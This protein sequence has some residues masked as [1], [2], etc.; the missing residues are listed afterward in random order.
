MG[1]STALFI[2]VIIALAIIASIVYVTVKKP[3]TNIFSY[4][5]STSN[6]IVSDLKCDNYSKYDIDCVDSLGRIVSDDFC[7]EEERPTEFEY[8]GQSCYFWQYDS[9]SCERE[10]E[11]IHMVIEN[12]DYTHLSKGDLTTLGNSLFRIDNMFYCNESNELY[13]I[14]NNKIETG[15]CTTYSDDDKWWE[16]GKVNTTY[17]T[18]VPY[19]E[20]ED[21]NILEKRSRTCRKAIDFDEDDKPSNSVDAS[22]S[23]CE[24]REF[25]QHRSESGE[26]IYDQS[27]SRPCS[28]YKV[29]IKKFE[30]YLDDSNNNTG[31]IFTGSDSKEMGNT[32]MYKLQKMKNCGRTCL[33]VTVS[34]CV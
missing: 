33:Y 14:D 32:N 17:L 7:V 5:W 29:L 15:T 4:K 30:E 13:D 25:I 11:K 6:A 8:F 18:V 34:L 22:M 2:C 1:K 10:A 21:Q 27:L 24:N 19:Y 28:E 31:V 26:L 23:F 9:W 16:T 20:G 12:E 3:S